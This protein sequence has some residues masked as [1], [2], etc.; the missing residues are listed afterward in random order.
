MAR[1]MTVSSVDKRYKLSITKSQTVVI[2]LSCKMSSNA[3]LTCIVLREFR[4]NLT[5]RLNIKLSTPE[6]LQII[7]K[8]L[9]KDQIKILEKSNK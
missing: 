3:C 6:A 7:T 5:Q 2:D 8:Q 9:Y 4:I 1:K